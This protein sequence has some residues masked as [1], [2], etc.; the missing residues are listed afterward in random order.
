MNLSLVLTENPHFL[1]FSSITKVSF[2]RTKRE[3]FY[4]HC[5]IGVLAYVVIS[6]HLI[7]KSIIWRLSSCKTII[8]W[9][10]LI[11]V[12]NH[13]LIS[14]IHL[15]LLFRKSFKNYLMINWRS[16]NLKIVF[17]S[18]IRVKSFFAFSDKF[19]KMLLSGLF[20][21][22]KCGGCNATCYW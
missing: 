13:F 20:Y 9:I 11:R 22:Y 6:R 15:T 17:T 19:P 2:R 4:T 7:L 16:C 1:E 3:D 12:L 18:P 21:K 8:S 14:G 10:L 5:F